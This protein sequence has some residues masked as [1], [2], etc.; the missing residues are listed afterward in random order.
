[1]LQEDKNDNRVAMVA[2][3]MKD[4]EKAWGK[5][6]FDSKRLLVRDPNSNWGS[7]GD[8]MN[9][10]MGNNKTRKGEK[11]KAKAPTIKIGAWDGTPVSFFAW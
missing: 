10:F 3:G 2:D 4:F 11:V 5:I 1:M 8:K 6:D 7:L 9:A